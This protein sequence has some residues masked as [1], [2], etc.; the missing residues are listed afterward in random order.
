MNMSNAVDMEVVNSED[1]AEHLAHQPPPQ[2]ELSLQERLSNL[3]GVPLPPHPPPLMSQ[4]P[5]RPFFEPR[6]PG[7]PMRGPMPRGGPRP[8]FRGS[9][10]RGGPRRPFQGR[11]IFRG[12]AGPRW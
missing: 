12:N 9:P 2:H 3:A 4:P 5:P 11:G 8:N 10:G 6:P 7:L 1:E